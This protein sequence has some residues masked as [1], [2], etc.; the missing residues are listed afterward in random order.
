MYICFLDGCQ[1][2]EETYKKK[3][4]NFRFFKN[5]LYKTNK[6]IEASMVLL[7]LLNDNLKYTKFKPFF[8]FFFHTNLRV[9]N[10]LKVF[11]CWVFIFKILI[12]ISNFQ[13]DYWTRNHFRFRCSKKCRNKNVSGLEPHQN[14]RRKKTFTVLRKLLKKNTFS[15]WFARV[16]LGIAKHA[17]EVK[18]LLLSSDILCWSYKIPLFEWIKNEK[19]IFFDD[20]KLGEGGAWYTKIY[21]SLKNNSS[22]RQTSSI[23]Y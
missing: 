12:Y 11:H 16:F 3:K 17:F 2:Y 6:T 22:W 5:L 15:I 18:M 8:L 19:N 21:M 13:I 23:I 7:C 1:I 20:A 14:K 4:T 10:S 9:S